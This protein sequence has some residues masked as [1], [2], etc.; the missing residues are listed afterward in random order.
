MKE[1]STLIKK[2]WWTKHW[3]SVHGL[4]KWTTLKKLSKWTTLKKLPK[5]TTL[6]NNPNEYHLMFLAASVIKLH[7][8]SA[9]VHPVQPLATIL[10][11]CTWS[12]Q[13]LNTNSEFEKHKLV[14]L[15]IKRYQSVSGSY[16]C[17]HNNLKSHWNVSEEPSLTFD[18]GIAQVTLN[19]G[20]L[21]PYMGYTVGM[22]SPKRGYGFSAVVWI[23]IGYVS[24]KK[25]L[26]HNYLK[27]LS[28][29]ALHKLG[30]K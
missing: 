10:N 20:G 24:W 11:N 16:K 18:L 5:W 13:L 15:S 4:P 19:A 17:K 29:N 1:Q 3:P 7:V 8:V 21:L 9:Y 6:K 30:W 14:L 23:Y 12:E 27:R 2:S 25:P 22:C 28:P 26:F